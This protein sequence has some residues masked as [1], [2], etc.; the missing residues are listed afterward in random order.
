MPALLDKPERW[1]KRAEE[2]RT[3]AAG[4]RDPE[5]K[6]IMLDL[7]ASYDALAKRAEDRKRAAKP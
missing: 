2:A 3:I 6:R 5:T 1:R 4:M 7:A